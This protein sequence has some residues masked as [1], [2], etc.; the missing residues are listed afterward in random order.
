MI[1]LLSIIELTIFIWLVYYLKRNSRESSRS[2]KATKNNVIWTF[3]CLLLFKVA[4]D[5]SYVFAISPVFSYSGLEL[6]INMIKLFESYI[7]FFI[8]SALIP[9]TGKKLSDVCIWL[10]ILISYTPMLTIFALKNESRIFMYMVTIFWIFV[11]LLLRT[12][13]IS[14]PSGGQPIKIYYCI[15]ICFGIVVFLLSYKYLGLSLNFDLTKVYDIRSDYLEA[16]VPLSG[17]IFNWQAYIINPIFLSIS[18]IRRKWLYTALIILFQIYLFSVTGVKAYFFSI[19][20]MLMLMYIVTRKNPFAYLAVIL[21]VFVSIGTMFYYYFD[22]IL[23][24]NFFVR[25]TFFVPSLLYFY[26]YDFFSEHGPLLLSSTRIFRAFIRYPY[27]LNPPHLIGREYFNSPEM[28]ANTG[29]VGD[30]YMNFGFIGFIFW[31]ILLVLILKLI[32]ACLKEK[33]IR[34]GVAGIASPVVALT[35]SA[36]LTNLL[37]HGLLLLLVLLYLLPNKLVTDIQYESRYGL[38]T[39]PHKE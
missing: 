10:L 12:P 27:D 8:V 23:I 29:I 18:I 34:V 35:N 31:G 15:F 26:T 37:T 21:T 1:I 13:K 11:F 2:L 32:D 24:I 38:Y 6:H 22:N 30:A 39:D 4:L 28:G 25:R 3:L 14:L 5:I 16:D 33:D 36:L 20:F 7:L 19:F 17:Y 9:K